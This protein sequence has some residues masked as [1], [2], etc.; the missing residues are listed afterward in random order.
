[1]SDPSNV[2]DLSGIPVYIDKGIRPCIL[3]AWNNYYGFTKY[4]IPRDA[5]QNTREGFYAFVPPT[6]ATIAFPSHYFHI[7]VLHNWLPL[8]E[9]KTCFVVK[10]YHIYCI[11]YARNNQW[12][13]LDWPNVKIYKTL[14][15]IQSSLGDT[16]YI[17]LLFPK[18]KINA[19]KDCVQLWTHPS[20]PYYDE[21]HKMLCTSFGT[22]GV[23]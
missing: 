7:C 21:F 12:I 18:N 14:W 10:E 20:T 2:F 6:H 8:I 17:I 23:A 11:K 5:V 16:R 22:S 4:D 1:M 19:L 3:R 9:C 13:T 15:D